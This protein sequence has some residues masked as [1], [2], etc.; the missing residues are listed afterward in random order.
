VKSALIAAFVSAVVASTTATAATVVVTS[1]NIK[2]GTIQTV[3]ISAKAKRVLRGQRGPRGAAGPAGPRGVQGVPGPQGPQGLRGSPGL[4]GPQG[5]EGPE[6]PEGP[7]GFVDAARITLTSAVA[8]PAA[9]NI[10]R[11]FIATDSTDGECLATANATNAEGPEAA[12]NVYCDSLELNGVHG[13]QITVVLVEG[14]PP[15][16]VFVVTVWQSGA[17]RYADPVRCPCG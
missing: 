17:Q 7:P 13:I 8:D 5:P 2:N 3:D 15:G 4:V 9:P 12:S 14:Q 11:A 16:L 1:K 6:G 10:L